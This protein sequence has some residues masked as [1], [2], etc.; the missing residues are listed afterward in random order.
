MSL[1]YYFEWIGEYDMDLIAKGRK[2]KRSVLFV[3]ILLA[4]FSS[5]ALKHFGYSI[6]YR[7]ACDF[8]AVFAVSILV[9]EVLTVR[10]LPYK[11]LYRLKSYS[12]I[13]PAT[14]IV[15]P[16]YDLICHFGGTSTQGLS[17]FF[18]LWIFMF[19]IIRKIHKTQKSCQ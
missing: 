5:G 13:L 14:A 6:Y 17:V 2:T 4:A 19:A 12:Y 15:W 8:F 9:E 3:A 11:L 10:E 1:N 18:A 7:I 16:S